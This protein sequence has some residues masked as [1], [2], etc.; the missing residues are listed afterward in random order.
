MENP[1]QE[2]AIAKS[3]LNDDSKWRLRSSGKDRYLPS[4]YGLASKSM[5]ASILKILL[6]GMVLL[7]IAAI[8][9][10]TAI[11]S[12]MQFNHQ[13]GVLTGNNIISLLLM[14]A[15]VIW[16]M[17]EVGNLGSAKERDLKFVV[18]T[19]EFFEFK[20]GSLG[21][22]LDGGIVN[23]YLEWDAIKYVHEYTNNKIDFI[24][25]DGYLLT[26]PKRFFDPGD[27]DTTWEEFK[28]EIRLRAPNASWHTIRGAQ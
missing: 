1:K 20:Y 18:I 12:N 9:M 13:F 15:L 6:V 19:W 24:N 23:Y 22:C 21:I 5:W 27:G 26:V 4:D 16:V 8:V 2:F 25:P 11:G 28:S 10:S 17:L 7:I 14:T 3:S